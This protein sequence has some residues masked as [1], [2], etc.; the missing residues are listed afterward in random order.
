MIYYLSITGNI[1][2]FVGKL[3]AE[4][5]SQD[6][7]GE[8]LV[9]EENSLFIFPTIGFGQPPQAAIDFLEKNSRYIAYL[10]GSGNRNWGCAFC[11]GADTLSK[12][13]NIPVLMKFELQGTDETVAVFKEKWN[14]ISRAK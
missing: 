14:A 1:R 12:Q 8:N 5:V 11:G 2:R 13:F 10:V 6:I 7:Q 9:L 3:G 4:F